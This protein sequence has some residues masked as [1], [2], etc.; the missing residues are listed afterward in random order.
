MS[1]GNYYD[2]KK[3]NPWRKIDTRSSIGVINKIKMYDRGFKVKR[4]DV[5]MAQ[6]NPVVGSE[7][8]GLHPVL[9]IQND[10]GNRF[11]PTIIVAVISTGGRHILP[12]QVP[13]NENEIGLD[14][15]SKVML[16]QIKT[17]DKSR[18]IQ[19]FG[20]LNE[21]V[22]EQVEEKVHLSLNLK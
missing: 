19:Y 9:V 13:V 10:K 6:L 1:Y 18:L 7:T 2:R 16:E 5:F 15:Y 3:P 14:P 11:S 17:I 21:A 20:R 22:M 8:G 12:M 4:G